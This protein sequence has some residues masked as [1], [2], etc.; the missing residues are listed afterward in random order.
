MEIEFKGH[1]YV[2]NQRMDLWEFVRE[3][4]SGEYM[5]YYDK[6]IFHTDANFTAAYVDSLDNYWNI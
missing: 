6:Y 2:L 3:S 5:R 4:K 1:K